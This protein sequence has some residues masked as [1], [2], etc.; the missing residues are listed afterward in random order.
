M[1]LVGCESKTC[2]L[3]KIISHVSNIVKRKLLITHEV[4]KSIPE[5]IIAV[6]FLGY[7]DW[8]VSLIRSIYIVW[9]MIP[10][11]EFPCTPTYSP[12]FTNFTKNLRKKKEHNH[13][14]SGRS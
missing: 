8:V 6:I 10:F 2:A 3:N 13:L 12:T 4:I 11:G 5:R 7:D 14:I 9:L 1:H